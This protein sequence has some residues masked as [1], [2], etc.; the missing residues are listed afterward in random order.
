LLQGSSPVTPVSP[1]PPITTDTSTQVYVGGY[2]QNSL[3]DYI[4]TS[5]KNDTLS[6]LTQGSTGKSQVNCIIVSGSDVYSVGNSGNTAMLW[7]NGV[8]IS[9]SDASFSSAYSIVISGNDVYIA[10]DTMS[11]GSNSPDGT[12]WLNGVPQYLENCEHANSILVTGSNV[13]VT[14]Q[15]GY[16]ATY[17]ENGNP[18]Y[19]TNGST[20]SLANSI[21]ISGNDIYVAGDTMTFS[22]QNTL[23][24]YWI[25]GI[26][27]PLDN[28]NHAACIAISNNDVYICGQGGIYNGATL[29][30]N[31]VAM[32]LSTTLNSEG[33]SIF[34]SG[35]DI[36]VA[37][38]TTGLNS[39]TVAAYWKNGAASY[40]TKGGIYS[41]ANSIFIN[42][43]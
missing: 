32:P 21:A 8:G 37:G 12:Y 39:S 40:L 23:G 6:S 1:V 18:V 16:Y 20:F 15:S 25:N 11:G 4:A 33:N 22:G 27:M 43:E 13:Y 31:N 3:G 9:L 42:K 19:L 17:W 30:E 36:Y 38:D 26:P 5:W 14:G 34:I 24:V 10:E 35:S 2:L 41:S 28:A 7:E 29:W